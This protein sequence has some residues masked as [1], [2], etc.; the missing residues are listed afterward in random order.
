[1][2]NYFKKLYQDPF[3]RYLAIGLAILGAVLF[4]TGDQQL[5]VVQAP[6]QQQ[7]PEEP[8]PAETEPLE[9]HF[10]YLPGCSHCED[11]E[12]FNQEL[13]ERYSSLYFVYHNG[14]Q[15]GEYET[16]K[17][18]IAG[19]DVTEDQL[20]FPATIVEDRVILGWDSEETTGVRIE[21]AVKQALEG[22]PEDE[23]APAESAEPDMEP[24]IPFIGTLKVSEYSLTSLAVI[25]GLVDGFNPCAMWV[26][27]YLICL[28]MVLKDKRRVWL[29]VGSFVA[30]SGVLYFLFMTAWLNAFLLIGYSRPVTIVVGLVAF[31][32]GVVNMKEFIETKGAVVCEVVDPESRKKTMSR[33]EQIVSSPLN[34]ATVLAIIGLA[35]VVNSIEFVCSAALP[36]IFTHV[37]ALSELPTM[38]YYGFIL[39]YVFF[40]ML[41]D[42]IIF[43]SAA[44]VMT[45]SLVQRYAGYSRP[46]GAIILLA[47]GA[48][49]LFAPGIL[50]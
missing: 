47:L 29:L 3:K 20:D 21:R 4:V 39:I 15:P 11:Q 42:L 50:G 41:D 33:I 17:E 5:E 46:V 14:T 23:Q 18:M 24:T 43:G 13:G 22:E 38:K 37:L 28:L 49:L 30:A 27:A 32:A 12:S 2:I 34:V 16:L 25:L 40:F 9:V 45:S 7:Q 36:A 8:A 10:F 31:G 19:T 48:L 1:M 26:L 44:M 35:F 6:E